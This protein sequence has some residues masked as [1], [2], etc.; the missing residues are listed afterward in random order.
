MLLVETTPHLTAVSVNPGPPA[1]VTAQTGATMDCVLTAMRDRGYG[2]AAHPGLGDLS[3]GGVLAVGAH[4]TGVPAAHE[5]LGPVHRFGSMS[6]LVES[7]TAVVWDPARRA[8]TLQTFDRS[9]GRCRALLVHLGRALVAEATL[10][11]GGDAYLRCESRCD[12]PADEV[13][14]APARAGPGSFAATV[15]RCGRV[16]ATWLPFT[17]APW[18]K[19]WSL[20]PTRPARAKAVTGPYNYPFADQVSKEASDLLRQVITTNGSSTPAFCNALMAAT[21]AGLAASG[22]SDIWGR[23]SD[24]L[25]HARP[26]KLRVTTLSYAIVTRRAAIQRVI[27][28]FYAY[29][30]AAVAD[31]QARGQYPMNGPLEVRVTGLDGTSPAVMAPQLSPIRPRCDRP[32]WDVAVWLDVATMP[33]TP[34]ANE[35]YRQTEAW[36]HANYAGVY[37]AARPEWS[38][39]WGYTADRGACTNAAMLATTIPD[40]YRVG[41]L[42]GDG[43]D[44]AKAPT[45]PWTRATSSAARS[46]TR[47]SGD[48]RGS[49]S[50]P[51]MAGC[52]DDGTAAG[53][54]RSERCA[55]ETP[56]R[57]HRCARELSVDLSRCLRDRRSRPPRD[58][59]RGCPGSCSCPHPRGCPGSCSCPRPGRSR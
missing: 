17:T 2:F 57:G 33:G 8:Y 21:I 44:A 30:S 50:A 9:D 19:C 59:S 43:W 56:P 48:L 40:A 58:P 6:D 34:A 55:C 18:M 31:Y 24:V 27:S 42:P 51:H 10:R 3:L 49:A 22:N 1:S 36:I 4:G 46:W 38:K 54:H 39:G 7:L 5:L 41:Q 16:E 32:D 11:I 29:L 47:S 37:A 20:A 14:A 25:L 12:I 15:E 13:F 23:S 53:T 35:F 45:T 26:T 28:E 52:S